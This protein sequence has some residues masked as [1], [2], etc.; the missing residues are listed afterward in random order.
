MSS[1]ADRFARFDPSAREPRPDPVWDHS[2][3]ASYL[4]DPPPDKPAWFDRHDAGF[5]SAE[6][7]GAL[8][9]VPG[10]YG[11]GGNWPSTTA[12]PPAYR[13]TEPGPA[14]S[15]PWHLHKPH[16]PKDYVRSDDR[17]REDICERLT[18][19]EYIDASG[20]DVF[21]E[22]GNV[23]LA[24]N[25]PDRRMKHTIEDIVESCLGVRNVDNRLRVGSIQSHR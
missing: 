20:V 23:T 19:S 15:G 9:D 21:V 17:I 4:P 7:Y 25:V 24:G 22:S 14:P 6:R 1:R 3:S 2:R 12:A 16:G 5:R 13:P 10:D 11:Y 18:Y 8:S